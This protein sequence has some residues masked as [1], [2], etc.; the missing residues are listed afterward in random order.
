MEQANALLINHLDGF[1]AR[2]AHR[3]FK[4]LE[5]I[6]PDQAMFLL[7]AI[8]LFDD[9]RRQPKDFPFPD[10]LR[11]DHEVFIVFAC[12]RLLRFATAKEF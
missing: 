1:C 5:R 6:G 12:G 7:L 8:N 3:F 2:R 4:A 9:P 11:E 10:R